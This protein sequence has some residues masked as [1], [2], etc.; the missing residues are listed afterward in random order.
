[1]NPHYDRQSAARSE[2]PARFNRRRIEKVDISDRSDRHAFIERYLELRDHVPSEIN[3]LI[4]AC[5]VASYAEGRFATRRD[6]TGYLDRIYSL[7]GF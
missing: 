2:P 1:M 4:V 3:R 6:L 7:H 5:G